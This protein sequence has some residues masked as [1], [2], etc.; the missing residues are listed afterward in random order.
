MFAKRV[1]SALASASLVLSLLPALPATA[2]AG[3]DTKTSSITWEYVEDDSFPIASDD[4]SWNGW[5]TTDLYYNEGI[6]DIPDGRYILK[7]EGEG[8]VEVDAEETLPWVS[9]DGGPALPSGA[10]VTGVEIGEGVTEIGEG[11]FK[12]NISIGNNDEQMEVDF[13]AFCASI[14]IPSTVTCIGA[15]AFPNIATGLSGLSDDGSYLQASIVINGISSEDVLSDDALK[16]AVSSGSYFNEVVAKDAVNTGSQLT[17]V[18]RNAFT[19]GGTWEGNSPARLM[20]G[21]A[22]P[23]GVSQGGEGNPEKRSFIA[24][25]ET[26]D[27]SM[28]NDGLSDDEYRISVL[29]VPKVGDPMSLTLDG[30]SFALGDD[31][32]Y[33]LRLTLGSTAVLPLRASDG[34]GSPVEGVTYEYVVSNSG[35]GVTVDEAGTLSAGTEEGTA[36]VTVTARAKGYATHQL[37]LNVKAEKPAL[38]LSLPT[39]EVFTALGSR[40]TCMLGVERSLN[41]RSALSALGEDGETVSNVSYT[42]STGGS[43]LLS[44]DEGAGTLTAGS[45]AGTATVEVS[46]AADGYQ[47]AS[48]KLEVHVFTGQEL[49]VRRNA[50]SVEL[51]YGDVEGTPRLPDVNDKLRGDNVLVVY[52]SADATGYAYVAPTVKSSD[53]SVV[54]GRWSAGNGL[55][56]TPGNKGKATVT[57]IF[58]QDSLATYQYCDA[59]EENG[60]YAAKEGSFSVTFEVEVVDPVPVLRLVPRDEGATQLNSSNVYVFKASK[61]DDGTASWGKAQVFDL[62]ATV[63]GREVKDVTLDDVNVSR[64]STT[65]QGAVEASFDA[66]AGTVT[67]IGRAH[68]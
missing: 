18:G 7:I 26:C 6:Q 54:T 36:T 37:T 42:V 12:G 62:V 1:I 8:A 49:K 30:D 44:Y 38:S 58:P 4:N 34:S 43:G 24:L 32:S 25:P 22:L 57:V 50:A 60:E 5:M 64:A 11:A 21:G 67:V 9:G 35:A 66:E 46:A 45:S 39:G 17:S 56:L 3:D 33:S 41:L 27:F 40:Y 59:T 19:A 63:L 29:K 65:N 52:N 51:Y 14:Q 28:L 68:V 13:L 31:G 15:E 16:T 10:V 2:F 23:T 20:Y 53:D 47:D 61:G 55:C 48:L